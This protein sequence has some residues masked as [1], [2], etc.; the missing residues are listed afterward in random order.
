M[1]SAYI[2]AGIRLEERDLVAQFGASYEQYRASV[3]M[4]VPRLFG[5]GTAS[6]SLA[7]ETRRGG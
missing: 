7:S 1:T 4:L 5:G 3:P 2:L 6:G